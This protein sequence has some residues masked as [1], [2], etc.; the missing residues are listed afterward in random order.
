MSGKLIVSKLPHMTVCPDRPGVV[1][2][3]GDAMTGMV[4][5]RHAA[6]IAH[7][8]NAYQA[9]Q[10]ATD[11]PGKIIE[12]LT[13][14]GSAG[15][16]DAPAVRI[17]WKPPADVIFAECSLAEAEIRYDNNLERSLCARLADRVAS[18][19]RGQ[20]VKDLADHPN[21]KYTLALWRMRKMSGP[22]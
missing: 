19:V 15:I 12:F 14:K 20:V 21:L 17:G 3:D 6:A 10:D 5:G 1:I 4:A 16:V 7:A 2:F 13:L 11:G 22:G 8:C 9:I 18:M